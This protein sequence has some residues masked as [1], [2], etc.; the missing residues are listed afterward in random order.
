[1][2]SVTIRGSYTSP[3]SFLA[4]GVEAT[5][6]RTALIDKLIDKGFVDLL[7]EKDA[8][9]PP[10][11]VTPEPESAPE[12]PDNAPEVPDNAPAPPPKNATREAWAEFLAAH[13]GGFITEGKSRD[14]LVGEWEV[15][16]DTHSAPPA[17]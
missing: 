17:E 9:S 3:S 15:Y 13:F 1:M 6:Q 14:Q 8:P 12:V 10:E 4:A 7:A 2:S 5:V 16:E 11:S